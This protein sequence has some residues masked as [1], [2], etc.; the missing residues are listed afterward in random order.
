MRPILVL[1]ACAMFSIAACRGPAPAELVVVGGM[2]DVM[3]DGH[4][5][6]RTSLQAFTAP[7][8]FGVGALA[9]LEGEILIDD[10]QV[11]VARS[12]EAVVP[13]A[14]TDQATLLVVARV[15]SFTTVILREAV[16]MF[17]LEQALAA[18]VP[19]ADAADAEP[20]PLVIEGEVEELDLHVVRGY[21][22][23]GVPKAGAQ[24]PERWSVASGEVAR[25]RLVG[26]FAVGREGLL[27]HHGTALHVH[28]LVDGSP[29]VMGHVD[30]LRLRA[31]ARLLLPANRCEQAGA[32]G[33]LGPGRR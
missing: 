6:A 15:P 26:L 9:G 23:H 1:S 3:R 5:E 22:P 30:A 8:S 29:R 31:G 25:V 27:T 16:D 18:A 14:D 28:A 11:L 12:T 7:G 21:C 17:G 24:P 10:G 20:L 32:P 2:R 19:G 13:A 4:T 33:Q